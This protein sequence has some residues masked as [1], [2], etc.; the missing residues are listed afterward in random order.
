MLLQHPWKCELNVK[1]DRI[2][3]LEIDIWSNKVGDY[4][5][6]TKPKEVIP[7]I[8]EVKGYGLRARPIKTEPPTD[9]LH[10]Y[11][12]DQLIDQAHALIDMAKTFVTKPVSH[13][14]PRKRPVKTTESGNIPKALDVLQDMTLNKLRTLHV[15]TDGSN[16]PSDSVPNTPK[17]RKIKCK[18]CDETFSSVKDLNLHHK[19]DHGIVKCTKC[20]KYFS[21]QSSLDKHSYSHGELKY[22]CELCGKCCPFQSRLDQHMMVHINNKLSCPKKSCDRQFK[23]I[24]DLNRHMNSH[25]KGGWYHCDHCD[26]K[27]KDKWNTDSHMRTHSTEEEYHYECDKCGKKMHFSTQYKCHREQGCN[28]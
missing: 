15:E 1:L 13:K 6:L 16:R 17:C 4:H 27:N 5:V 8:S 12:T 14:H 26:Y 19:Q 7:I 10:E 18:M 24:W 2:Q 22:N 9:D 21:T 25:T 20:D 23:S 28:V 11:K 3:P